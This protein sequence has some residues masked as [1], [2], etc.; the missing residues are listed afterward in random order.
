VQEKKAN[1]KKLLFSS[2][3]L[4]ETNSQK[5]IFKKLKNSMK[6]LTNEI[7]EA[8]YIKA[9]ES[10]STLI[11]TNGKSNMY[12]RPMKYFAEILIE[13]GWFK[14]HKSYMVNPQFIAH[15]TSDRESIL[16]QNGKLLPI[17]RRKLPFVLK[18]RNN[19]IGSN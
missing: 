17:S 11:L 13:K 2:F 7:K 9:A 5:V 12:S 16:L 18:W 4:K 3:F 15:I 1:H 6:N 14:I 19:N 10:Y 8:I